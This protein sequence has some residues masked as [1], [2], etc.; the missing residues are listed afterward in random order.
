MSLNHIVEGGL[1]D[2]TLD[3]KGI[4]IQ[5]VP[6]GLKSLS[7]TEASYP[8]LDL[9]GVGNV[10]LA[11]GPSTTVTGVTGLTDGQSV[12]F[13][14]C[15]QASSITIQSFGTIQTSTGSNIVLSG[16]GECAQAVWSDALGYLTVVQTS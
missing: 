5:G 2:I 14:T 12:V 1:A 9:T 15:K 7:L 16:V 13:M 4:T 6:V 10:Y 8:A 11:S 3:V